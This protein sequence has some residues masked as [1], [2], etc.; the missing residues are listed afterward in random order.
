M[1]DEECKTFRLDS[2]KHAKEGHLGPGGIKAGLVAATATSALH[3]FDEKDEE[4]SYDDSYDDSEDDDSDSSS[5]DDDNL[6]RS[7][8]SSSQ[9]RND[10]TG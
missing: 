8:G 10:T 7:S 4:D 3:S 2:V 6:H 1:G 9:S 5:T